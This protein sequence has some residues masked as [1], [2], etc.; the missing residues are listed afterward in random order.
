MAFIGPN[1]FRCPSIIT[2]F[3]ARDW[4]LLRESFTSHLIPLRVLCTIAA[5][6]V[7]AVHLPFILALIPFRSRW[8]RYAI[9]RRW[10]DDICY[11]SSGIMER[12]GS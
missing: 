10:G 12:G 5:V 2:S 8:R 1:V 9:R 11:A 4:T 7:V 3:S 6:F